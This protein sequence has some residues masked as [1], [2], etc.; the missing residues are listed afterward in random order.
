MSRCAWNITAKNPGDVIILNFTDF[1]VQVG[2]HGMI[3]DED[4]VQISDGKL[5]I[6]CRNC[7]MAWHLAK[8]QL[9]TFPH[10]TLLCNNDISVVFFHKRKALLKSS[11][12]ITI[13]TANLNFY[14]REQWAYD[15]TLLPSFSYLH[16]L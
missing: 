1:D 11:E 12:S 16:T 14:S 6:L 7:V 2:S 10:I 3:C 5:K 9:S 4:W 13:G 8:W 15:P